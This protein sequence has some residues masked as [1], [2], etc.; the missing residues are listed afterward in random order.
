MTNELFL[1][2]TFAGFENL[3]QKELL[4]LGAKHTIILNRSVQFEGDFNLLYKVNY[5]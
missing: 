4:E 1:A 5:Y 3:L 2:K